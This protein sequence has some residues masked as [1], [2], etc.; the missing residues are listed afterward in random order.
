MERD[1][2]TW[3]ERVHLVVE[4]NGFPED[5][6]FTFSYSPVHDERGRVG[7]L[8]NACHEDTPQ[9]L[10]ERERDRLAEQRRRADASLRDAERRYRA[11]FQS[12]R[13]GRV[14]YTPDG[15][16]VEANPAACAMY[17]YTPD[18]MRGVHAPSAIHPDARPMFREFQ[19]VASSGGE[20]RCEAVDRRR[21]GTREA[22]QACSGS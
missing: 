5:A 15:T 16:V 10:A 4:R 9:V 22:S 8:F 7:G 6:W 1:E 18:E 2:S 20:F 14:I 17:G 19:R 11:V 3:N 21:D 12:S 13:D